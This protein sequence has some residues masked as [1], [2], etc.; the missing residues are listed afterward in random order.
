MALLWNHDKLKAP[1]MGLH[2]C[3]LFISIIYQFHTM[4]Y[5]RSRSKK[6]CEESEKWRRAT[7]FFFCA[8]AVETFDFCWAESKKLI[9]AIGKKTFKKLHLRRNPKAFSSKDWVS[10]T[11]E[12]LRLNLLLV[13]F[14]K[15]KLWLL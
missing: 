14:Y 7:I 12:D 3:R 8:V 13:I 9:E 15:C 2:V 10:L 4:K 5:W 1:D 11:N 6:K